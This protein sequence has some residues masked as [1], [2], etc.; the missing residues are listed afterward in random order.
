MKC[1]EVKSQESRVKSILES[2]F[3]HFAMVIDFRSSALVTDQ[4]LMFNDKCSML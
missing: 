1:V 2:N 4:C 3:Q